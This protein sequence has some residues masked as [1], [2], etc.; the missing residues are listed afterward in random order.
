VAVTIPV[1]E[2]QTYR[3]LKSVWEGNDKLTVEDLATALGMNP[4]EV[5]DGLRIDAGLKNVAG[6]YAKRGYLNATVKESIE[7]DDASSTVTFRFNINEGPRYFMGSLIVNGLPTADA[8]DLKSRWTMG[9]TAVF[10]ESYL[11]TFRT[12]SLRD[13]M[14]ALGQRSRGPRLKVEV[15]TRPNIQQQTVDVVFTFR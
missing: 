14:V 4:G 15:E 7:F 12:T 5:A 11:E 6:A 3:W 8:D 9:S 10:D 1:E 2:G 13:F